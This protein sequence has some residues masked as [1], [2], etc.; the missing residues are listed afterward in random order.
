MGSLLNFSKRA[1]TGILTV[2]MILTAAPSYAFATEV[3][4][5][6]DK[7]VVVSEDGNDTL[8]DGEALEEEIIHESGEISQEEQQDESGTD[9]VLSD[10]EN[11]TTEDSVEAEEGEVEQDQLLDE[12]HYWVEFNMY[13]NIDAIGYNLEDG[14][15]YGDPE[16]YS[17]GIYIEKGGS[18]SFKLTVD[19]GYRIV[20][21]AKIIYKEEI[22]VE[23]TPDEDGVYKIEDVNDSTEIRVYSTNRSDNTGI[24]LTKRTDYIW[25]G[26]EGE[27]DYTIELEGVTVEG[28]NNYSADGTNDISVKIDLLERLHSHSFYASYYFETESYQGRGGEHYTRVNF[29]ELNDNSDGATSGSFSIS[30]GYVQEAIEAGSDI[31]IDIEA[32]HNTG[33][34]E[35]SDNGTAY[36][37]K[38]GTGKDD[39]ICTMTSYP[40]CSLI[41]A[42]RDL[43]FVIDNLPDGREVSYV[44]AWHADVLWNPSK[45]GKST[46]YNK[47]TPVI[48][49]PIADNVDD[50][51]NYY[52]ILPWELATGYTYLEII[53]DTTTNDK[54]NVKFS[55]DSGAEVTITAP[56]D[57]AGVVRAGQ[58]VPVSSGTT[59][60]FN[61]TA[62]NL[63]EIKSV[64]KTF[65]DP[66]ETEE[67]SGT[68]TEDKY[69]LKS[70]GSYSVE[71]EDDTVISPEFEKYHWVNFRDVN[72]KSIGVTPLPKSPDESEESDFIPQS[73]WRGR[74]PVKDRGKLYFQYNAECGYEV[75]KVTTTV[76][77]GA[78]TDLNLLETNKNGRYGRYTLSTYK[79]DNVTAETTIN[80]YSEEVPMNLVWLGDNNSSRGMF[81]FDGV[82]DANVTASN[83]MGEFYNE[84]TRLW[85][86]DD[87]SKPIKFKVQKDDTQIDSVKYRVI[88]SF[89]EWN[90]DGSRVLK[91]EPDTGY[92]QTTVISP[93]E[94]GVYSITL[95]EGWAANNLGLEITPVVTELATV[96]INAFDATK[97]ENNNDLDGRL[98][99]VAV[100]VGSRTYPAEY[101]VDSN[102]YTATVPAGSAVTATVTSADGLWSVTNA[103]VTDSKGENKKLSAAKTGEYALALGADTEIATLRIAAA[104]A[105]SLVITDNNGNAL[106]A[107][108]NVYT[109]DSSESFK[110]KVLYGSSFGG[111]DGNGKK[112]F[113]PILATGTTFA[114]GSVAL[115]NDDKYPGATVESGVL[116]A[117]GEAFGNKKLTLNATLDKKKLST[118]I[119]FTVTPT[120]VKVTGM[121]KTGALKVPYGSKQSIA[122]TFAPS[123]ANVSNVKAYIWKYEEETSKEEINGKY[124]TFDGKTVVIDPKKAFGQ[125]Y[126]KPGS[127][128]NGWFE[129]GFFD[130]NTPMT[131]SGTENATVVSLQ[132][133]APDISVAPTVKE[134][135]AIATNQTLGLSL[136][137]PKGVKAV[138]GMYYLI[139]ATTTENVYQYRP[140][141]DDSPKVGKEYFTQNEEN[142]EFVLFNGSTFEDNVTYFERVKVYKGSVEGYLPASEKTCTL[143]VADSPESAEDGWNIAYDVTAKLV[144]AT[145]TNTGY[146]I[147]SAG[148]ESGVV[149]ANTKD[150]TYET[151]LTLTKKVPAKVYNS[152]MNV[153]IAI[154]KYSKTTTVQG[155]D[156]IELRDASGNVRGHWDRWSDEG[157]LISVDETGLITLDTEWTYIDENDGNKEKT[158]HL[159]AGK[160]TVVAYAIGGPGQMASASVP[161]TVVEAIRSIEVE[162]PERV[163]KAYNKA[164]TVKTN[165]YY[166]VNEDEF[167]PSDKKADWDIVQVATAATVD[168]PATYKAVDENSPLYGMV[169][170]KNGTATINKNLLVDLANHEPDEY[171]FVIKATAADYNGN[172][173]VGYSDPIAITSDSLVPTEI[174]FIW[175]KYDDSGKVTGTH[176]SR[177]NESEIARI[178]ANA[179]A[180]VKDVFLEPFYS[181][182]I[183]NTRVRVLDQYGNPMSASLK[184]SG[185]KQNSEGELILEKTGKVT[186]TATS[187][188]GG[189]KSKKIEFTIAD[190]DQRFTPNVLIQNARREWDDPE[191]FLNITGTNEKNEPNTRWDTAG[192][193][194]C[195]NDLPANRYLYVHVAGIRY[196]DMNADG[197]V[198][199]SGANEYGNNNFIKHSVKVKGGTIKRT[200]TGVLDNYTTY[201]ILPS[202][203][204]TVVTV[205]DNTVDK[206]SGRAKQDYE[207]KI[208]NSA[209]SNTKAYTIKAD[210]A[211]ILSHM[212]VRTDMYNDATNPNHV[213]YTI[214]KCPDV[215]DNSKTLVARLTA[216]DV[217]LRTDGMH[218]IS[219]FLGMDGPQGWSE[220]AY[221]PVENGKFALDYFKVE[222]DNESGDDYYSFW[223]TPA[224]TYNFYVT[225]GEATKTISE[226]VT[227]YSDFTA[228]AQPV[229][230][231]VKV[232]AAPTPTVKFA[233]TAF[234]LVENTVGDITWCDTIDLPTV[235]KGLGIDSYYET[236]SANT[237]GNTN[238]FR[239][240]FTTGFG[241]APQTPLSSKAYLIP[242]N[243]VDDWIAVGTG[244]NT[245]YVHVLS[246]SDLNHLKNGDFKVDLPV[247]D[248]APSGEYSNEENAV[249]AGSNQKTA[250]ADQKKAY[251]AWA[252]TN[253]TGFIKCSTIGYDGT[254]REVF[255]KVTVNMD[256]FVGSN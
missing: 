164:A 229:K 163:F 253:G 177:I 66:E 122:V 254:Y 251:A 218:V 71:V 140:T 166:N 187:T 105:M 25:S 124:G 139:K 152:E 94:D 93:D 104:P 15:Y 157:E 51:T 245:V 42:H 69:G 27:P 38:Q 43:P 81:V 197:T 202:A 223:D 120:S 240:L 190:S 232:A 138:E 53:T 212:W 239:E 110:A 131:V 194:T 228:L 18:L 215:T 115:P 2:A 3:V 216:D 56:K 171:E 175:N 167:T 179:K 61:V 255:T 243:G 196:A 238:R 54:K 49:T 24:N 133:T 11:D 64:T 188:D 35:F 5:D 95:P 158:A 17:G 198:T 101:D 256:D 162:A 70:L 41:D 103:Y 78:E 108:K 235:T 113:A 225:L 62:H 60:S 127:G 234:K 241:A 75:T 135:A 97:D 226:G 170:V 111:F 12:D 180:K 47:V 85:Y 67:V 14:D 192:D 58:S 7:Q 219:Q 200:L 210:K 73:N 96:E 8:T 249:L 208:T 252:K 137:L 220:G 33:G 29:S 206:A 57:L 63:Q 178:A 128:D 250:A 150:N 86:I 16:Q 172:T 83:S 186:V 176:Y 65:G 246:W 159:E 222:H 28:E 211:S 4:D 244:K 129:L 230:V 87:G 199:P 74:V 134:N 68:L 26:H 237:G 121:D 6:T 36:Y 13:P 205:T 156:N 125:K 48:L 143:S 23:L 154:P 109:L 59:L 149:S 169:T 79:I 221:Y 148:S 207:Y 20:K 147:Q 153:P 37:Y 183:Q 84:S 34:V 247:G 145:K 173:T 144:Y 21:V 174:Q 126:Y 193:L 123:G 80:M 161:V 112:I 184:L 201:V 118:T 89:N 195:T 90:N 203:E 88:H 248:E 9:V 242:K 119:N 10:N 233:K 213:V 1:L 146:D 50:N 44:R 32:Y 31:R 52:Y 82:E 209:I 165:I 72:E 30:A 132:F 236:V 204:E 76:D 106:E 160:Y 39:E 168:T 22:D 116:T 102:R 92:T 182:D 191:S 217:V 40:R 142:G 114:N 189:N 45:V 214:D 107:V 99:D 185:I 91:Y 77:G 136:A 55:W 19:E 117:K 141:E 98:F 231:S 151:K 155:L 46:V 224:G 181:G 100:R 227:T 130:G